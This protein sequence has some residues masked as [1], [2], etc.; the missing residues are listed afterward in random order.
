MRYRAIQKAMKA[1]R[2]NRR[3]V[4]EK[5]TAAIQ[6][7]LVEMKIEAEVTGREKNTYSIYKKTSE[8]SMSFA[9]INDIY[10]FRIIS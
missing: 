4:V 3:E 6:Q 2:G 8:K 9:Q 5:I 1:S 10:A 7:K